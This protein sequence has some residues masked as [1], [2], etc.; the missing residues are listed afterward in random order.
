TERDGLPAAEIRAIAQDRNGYLWIGTSAGLVRFDGVR[1][2]HWDAL[3]GPA[4][5]S[6]SVNVLCASR[7]GSLWI[8]FVNTP[9]LFY[10]RDAHLKTY[11]RQ[12]GLPA[13]VITAL[14]EEHERVMWARGAGGLARSG[15]QYWQPRGPGQQPGPA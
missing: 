13:G 1:F 12:D 8:G 15:D 5:P 14:L 3:G 10:I 4:L 6:A 7:D 9:G 11:G 2:V